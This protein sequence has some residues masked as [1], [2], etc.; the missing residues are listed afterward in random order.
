[1]ESHVEEHYASSYSSDEE[2][3]RWV[4]TSQ[5]D[6]GSDM[7]KGLKAFHSMVSMNGFIRDEQKNSDLALYC[8][9]LSFW[10]QLW[11]PF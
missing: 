1:M 7:S 11:V 5:P 10:L 4:Y 6:V 2:C 9:N 8:T 3:Q